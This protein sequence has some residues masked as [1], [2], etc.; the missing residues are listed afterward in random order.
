M[1]KMSL[2]R[3]IAKQVHPDLNG[4]SVNATK[5]M[6]EAIKYRNNDS[7]LLSLARRWGLNLNGTFNENLFNKK[8]DSRGSTGVFD[9]VVGA[10]VKY[11]FVR[12]NKNISIKGV[13]ISIRTITK[14]RF[15]GASEYSIYDFPARMVW[16]HKSFSKPNFEVVGQASKDELQV[17]QDT[18]QRIKDS[19][20]M[21]GYTRQNIANDRFRTLGLLKNKIYMGR[22]M[23][24]YINYKGGPE[25]REIVRTTSKCVFV[26]ESLIGERMINIKSVLE[27]KNG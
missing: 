8:S 9:I 3:D 12:G 24:A 10:I 22:G 13:I 19:K 6:Q 4:N 2:F 25:W 23:S 17:G 1:S 7:M 11:A 20:K 16:K 5:M 26:R 21:A 18:Q 27:V 14:G 15:R